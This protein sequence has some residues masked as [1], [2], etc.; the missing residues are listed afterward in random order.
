MEYQPHEPRADAALAPSAA[1]ESA[2]PAA[3]LQVSIAALIVVAFIGLW[4]YILGSYIFWVVTVPLQGVSLWKSETF[5]T[6]KEQL[7]LVFFMMATF[8]LIALHVVVLFAYLRGHRWAA[9]VLT[10]SLLLGMLCTL[11]VLLLLGVVMAGLNGAPME[12]VEFLLD[13]NSS[14]L[15]VPLYV[16]MP[17]LVVSVAA[18]GLIWSRKARDYM[19]ARSLWRAEKREN[20]L[21]F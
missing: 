7:P 2:K 4:T 13:S 14:P 3:P 5:L 10:A 17:Y 12:E 8:V 6:L 15:Y 21:L 1:A 11:I 9:Y 18:L 19:Q 16:G 20:S